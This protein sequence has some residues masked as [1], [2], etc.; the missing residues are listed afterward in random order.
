MSYHQSQWSISCGVPPPGTG[1]VPVREAA[2]IDRKFVPLPRLVNLLLGTFL[3]SCAV[4]S[5][6]TSSIN[7]AT[8]SR[9]P[10]FSN[11]PFTRPVTVG[12]A[13]PTNCQIGQLFFNSTAAPGTN[14]FACTA[15]NTWTTLASSGI[16]TPAITVAPSSLSFGNQTVG[17]TSA[18]KSLTLS[19]IGTTFLSLSGITVSGGNSSD[20]LISSNCGSVVAS[21]STCTLSVSF[22]PSSVAAETTSVAISGNQP[23]SPLIVAATGTGIT[24]I[25]SGGLVVTPSATFAAENGT[26]TLTTNRPVNWS[27]ASGS[28]GTLISNSATSATF[29]APATIT[30]QNVIGSCQALPN[31][32]VFNTRIDNLPLE[33][34]S[35]TW[36]ANMGS[37]GLNFLTGWGTNIADSTTPV[38][39]LGFYYT[40][41][42]NGP[43]VV[44]QWPQ[45]KRE[46]GTFATR[47]NSTDHHILTVR[48]D[49]C[50]FYEIYNDWFTPGTCRDGVTPGCNAQSGLTYA[51]NSYALP[52]GGSTDAAGLPLGPLMLSLDELRRGVISHAVRFTVS[53]GFIQAKPYWPANSGN[54][55]G[56]CVNSPPYGARFRLKAS[57][58][59][60]KFG[61][62]AQTILTGLKR[63]GMMLADAGTGPTIEVST[64]VSEDT[65]AMGALGQ[66]ASAQINMTNFEAVDESSFIVSN[67]SAQVNPAN[68]YQTPAAFAVV[69]ATDQSNSNY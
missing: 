49:N 58:D 11:F 17:T 53:G 22:K 45:L 66:I 15:A 5:A 50:Q 10:D 24:A 60:S 51:W 18:A 35:A 69:I 6:Q 9:N 4:S 39:S 32:A 62:M 44:P 55:C 57:Y 42:Y 21:G 43:F 40:P 30:P 7:L 14:L 68:G 67:S 36:T 19:N 64:D 59:I 8:Q 23:G 54:G 3:L 65:N 61:T 16:P 47:L 26:V 33:S 1:S 46:G 52:P 31:D 28:S 20:F 34:H 25:T 12:T 38:R 37:N 2:A 63:Y 48:K 27:M 29:V 13:L 56:G 41:Y